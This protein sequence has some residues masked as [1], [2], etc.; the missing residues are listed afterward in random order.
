MAEDPVDRARLVAQ[1]RTDIDETGRRIASAA[2]ILSRVHFRLI[3]VDQLHLPYPWDAPREVLKP[4]GLEPHLLVAIALQVNRAI[5]LILRQG[6]LSPRSAV[7]EVDPIG[8]RGG[9]P[10][11]E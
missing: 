10:V 11:L 1:G 4:D 7:P 3:A 8:P 2:D 5:P 6:S 9:L